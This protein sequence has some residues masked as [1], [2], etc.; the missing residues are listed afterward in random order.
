MTA[1]L[2]ED[3]GTT[4]VATTTDLNITG[5]PQ[6]GRGV[7]N[8]VANKIVASPRIE[9]LIE[10]RRVSPELRDD[11]FVVLPFAVASIALTRDRRGAR[12]SGHRPIR[13][14]SPADAGETHPATRLTSR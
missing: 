1:R 8:D 11:L 12:C 14:R 13:P 7:M 10:R 9:S 2:T 4:T 3:A 5:K 6:F